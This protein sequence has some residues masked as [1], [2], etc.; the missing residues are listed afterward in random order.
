MSNFWGRFFMFSWAKKKKIENIAA[1]ALKSCIEKR[2]KKIFFVG[3]FFYFY[4]LVFFYRLILFW[5]KSA[6]HRGP[7]TMVSV[8]V[9][10]YNFQQLW[11]W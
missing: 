7:Y 10:D 1:S 9:S 8:K 11:V 3:E 6:I 2:L 4:F 5:N